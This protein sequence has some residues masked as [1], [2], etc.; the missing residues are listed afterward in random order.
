VFFCHN[1]GLARST[2]R[3]SSGLRV[4]GSSD[5]AAGLAIRELMRSQIASMHQGMR[6]AN[7][8]VSLIQAADGA[9][10]IVDEKA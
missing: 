7:D 5:D 2:E 9:L 4:N 6:N 8:A 3:L 10:Q 1:F